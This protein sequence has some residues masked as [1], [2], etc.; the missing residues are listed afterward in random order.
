MKDF[1][2]IIESKD[3]EN[4]ISI[5]LGIR[6]KIGDHETICP[7]LEICPSFETFNTEIQTLKTSLDSVLNKAKRIFEGDTPDSITMLTADMTPNEIWETLSFMEN[8]NAIVD[9]FNSLDLEKRREVAE[10]I[11]TRCN[12]FSGMG[13]VFSSR[14]N[15]E[16]GL[17]E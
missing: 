5:S 14:Y 17:L 10:Y 16:S 4:K 13:S 8:V 6:L 9:S 7:I 2:E 12:I 3:N 1:F 15:S 11:L